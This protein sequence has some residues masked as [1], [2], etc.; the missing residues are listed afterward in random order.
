VPDLLAGLTPAAPG[1]HPA[2]PAAPPGRLRAAEYA[3]IVARVVALISERVAPG[4]GVLVV[5][6]GDDALL[7][8]PGRACAHFPQ[9]EDGAWAGFHPADTVSAV[10]QLEA[11]HTAGA[12][13][14]LVPVTAFWW[15]E[16]YRGLWEHLTTAWRLEAVQ[17]DTAVL[18]TAPAETRE[19]PSRPPADERVDAAARLSEL[20]AW[21]VPPG[22]RI[23][24]ITDGTPGIAER[25]PAVA[26][27]LPWG[28][29]D[30]SAVP[31]D[32]PAALR[33]LADEGVRHV[34]VPGQWRV[35]LARLPALAGHRVVTTQRHLGAMFELHPNS[36]GVPLG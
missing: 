25:L 36:Q 1:S 21:L 19:E 31:G 2:A 13:H 4:A 8:A 11:L 20:A 35:I 3:G 27:A 12:R 15:F 32:V 5:S 23:G 10:A 18:F 17:A 7:A 33:R 34:L 29:E 14:L 24:V 16:H 22:A 26:V 30:A 28:G 6:R 9:G